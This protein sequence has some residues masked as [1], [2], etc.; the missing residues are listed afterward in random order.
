MA[1]SSQALAAQSSAGAAAA[2]AQAIIDGLRA[3]KAAANETFSNVT[4]AWGEPAAAMP[5]PYEVTPSSSVHNFASDVQLA[6]LNAAQ[7]MAGLL[8]PE[9]IAAATPGRFPVAQADKAALT[10]SIPAAPKDELALVKT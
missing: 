3:R 10:A 7:P 8:A 9:A 5:V 4:M 1:Q 2:R 6:A